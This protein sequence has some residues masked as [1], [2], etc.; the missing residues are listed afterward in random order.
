MDSLHIFPKDI[1]IHIQSF[2]FPKYI[3][4]QFDVRIYPVH[5]KLSHK[6]LIKEALYARRYKTPYLFYHRMYV[7]L[8]SN[9]TQA[10]NLV[11]ELDIIDTLIFE[12]DV[13]EFSLNGYLLRA[14]GGVYRPILTTK[15]ATQ[16]Q[17]F[18]ASFQAWLSQVIIHPRPIAIIGGFINRKIKENFY[19]TDGYIQYEYEPYGSCV[20]S[21]C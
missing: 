8:P 13:D 19:L 2:L 4:E 9:D 1:Q 10:F 16:I 15:C 21:A 11:C 12:S 5:K 7:D 17:W 3:N 14:Q 6:E 20:V 18:F